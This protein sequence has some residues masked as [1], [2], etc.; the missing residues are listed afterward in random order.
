MRFLN[1]EK[2]TEVQSGYLMPS[3]QF[4]AGFRLNLLFLKAVFSTA[5]CRMLIGVVGSRVSCVK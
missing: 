3:D 1:S 4:R 5:F 2:E